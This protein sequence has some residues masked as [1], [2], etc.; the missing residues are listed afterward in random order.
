MNTKTALVGSALRVVH[1]DA[2]ALFVTNGADN[3]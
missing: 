3:S 1:K 2:H